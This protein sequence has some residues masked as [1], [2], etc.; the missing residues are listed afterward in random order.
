R[1]EDV[2]NVLRTW[3]ADSQVRKP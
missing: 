3:L 1:P 2:A